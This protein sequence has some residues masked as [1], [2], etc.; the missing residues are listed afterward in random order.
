V[1]AMSD[2]FAGLKTVLEANMTSPQTV[3]VYTGP[4]DSINQFPAIVL[5][6]DDFDPRIAVGGNSFELGI[7][8]TLLVAQVDSR[9]AYPQLYDYLDPTASSES[10]KAAL[11]AD[12]T[13]DGKVDDSDVTSYSQIGRR[14]INDTAYA[15][16][17][18]RV[19]VI[20]TVA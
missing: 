15:G 11:Y 1:S 19:E 4:P 3:R 20:K 5:R 14:D 18:F 8:C 16:F 7:I 12:R 13:L 2:I 10:V 9:N 6:P 17:D